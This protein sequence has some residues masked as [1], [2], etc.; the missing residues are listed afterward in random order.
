MSTNS[1]TCSTRPSGKNDNAADRYVPNGFGDG[2]KL[3]SGNCSDNR[4]NR[5]LT[6]QSF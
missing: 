6:A 1:A 3:R 4:K 2:E 5:L